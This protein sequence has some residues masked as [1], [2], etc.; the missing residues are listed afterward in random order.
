MHNVVQN[1]HVI[2]MNDKEK[3]NE[4]LTSSTS[5]GEFD[6]VG[7]GV[8]AEPPSFFGGGEFSGA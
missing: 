1:Q 4:K 8:G 3:R 2:F 5:T 7:V 6:N